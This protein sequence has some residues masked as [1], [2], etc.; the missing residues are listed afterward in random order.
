MSATYNELESIRYVKFDGKN[1]DEWRTWSSKSRAIGSIRS[2]VLALDND[3]TAGISATTTDDGE[4]E[5]NPTGG[6]GVYTY[7]WIPTGDVI[8]N[9]TTLPP[10]GA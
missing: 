7:I 2:W 4:L 5:A 8:A 3:I 1:E 6:T 9:P 10:K